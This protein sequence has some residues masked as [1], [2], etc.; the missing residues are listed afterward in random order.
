[1]PLSSTLLSEQAAL[2]CWCTQEYIAQ[3]EIRA[4]IN[5][6]QIELVRK[7]T[8]LALRKDQKIA[9]A[10]RDTLKVASGVHGAGILIR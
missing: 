8:Q 5:I 6:K 7:M 4:L 3:L 2:N 9:R 10:Q 1:M